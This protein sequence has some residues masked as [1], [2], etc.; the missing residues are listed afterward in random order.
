MLQHERRMLD[1]GLLGAETLEGNTSPN[2]TQ[3][4]TEHKAQHKLNLRNTGARREGVG[5]AAG[6]PLHTSAHTLFTPY[7][8]PVH[9]HIYIVP[10]VT[11]AR[12]EGVGS[13]ERGPLH[14]WVCPFEQRSGG[15]SS[16]TVE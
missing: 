7:P 13:A 12:R 14:L 6:G 10:L 1:V 2:E 4:I 5:R 15:L 8:H 9:V 16:K 3:D 11:G